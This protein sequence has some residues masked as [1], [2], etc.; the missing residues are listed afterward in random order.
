VW[1]RAKR[2][3]IAYDHNEVGKLLALR[4]REARK[5]CFIFIILILN[6]LGFSFKITTMI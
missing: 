1:T 5:T 2:T 3:F 4:G 6:F